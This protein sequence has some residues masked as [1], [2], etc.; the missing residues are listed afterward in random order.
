[1]RFQLAHPR[2]Q[3]VAII[4]RI[5]SNGMTTLPGGNL[6][7]KEENGD[8]W[9]TPAGIDKGKPAP[10][11]INRLRAGGQVES[12]HRPSSE[13]PFHRAICARRPDLGAIVHA[14]PLLWS[15]S[16]ASPSSP[17]PASS[18]SPNESAAPWGTR[19]A[20]LA[21][22]DIAFEICYPVLQRNQK[23]VSRK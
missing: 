10:S 3:L 21:G 8:I 6:S 16:A 7:I 14:H 12:P 23:S 11:D 15:H 22:F 19:P 1:M 4:N 17:T 5:Y 9:I 13:H 2:D 20:S 18:H